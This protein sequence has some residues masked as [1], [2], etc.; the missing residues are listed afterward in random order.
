MWGFPSLSLQVWYYPRM[1]HRTQEI[2]LLTIYWFIIT[3]LRNNQMEEMHRGRSQGAELP[4]PLRVQHLPSTST[5]S[6]TQLPKSCLGAP[7]EVSYVGMPDEHI[8]RWGLKSI[9]SPSPFPRCWEKGLKFP[10]PKS[11][12]CQQATH[13]DLQGFLKVLSLTKTLVW[14]KGTCY[15]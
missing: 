1:T 9:S 8:G 7:V 6:P 11:H 15:K 4:C 5:R 13:P 3:Q 10:S 2:A 14:L 12:G